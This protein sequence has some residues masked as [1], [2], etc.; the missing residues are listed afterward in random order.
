MWELIKW[1]AKRKYFDLLLNSLIFFFLETYE[2]ESGEGGGVVWI[3]SDREMIEEFFGEEKFWQVF[4][5]G[6]LI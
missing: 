6:S 1:S 5:W 4:F 3:S 2:D